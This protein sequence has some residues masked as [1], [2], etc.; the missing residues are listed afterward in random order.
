MKRKAFIG[1][2]GPIAYD[3]NNQSKNEFPS[4]HSS[5]NPILE[6]S[7]GLLLFY[8]ELIFLSPQL[9]PKNMRSLDFVKFLI[10]YEDFENKY[11]KALS[12]AEKIMVDKEKS[13]FQKSNPLYINTI[14]T[15]INS[16]SNKENFLTDHH[17]HK[18]NL[19]SN[20]VV[21][22]ASL[23]FNLVYVD[24][25]LIEE[26]NLKNCELI[27]NS[28][29]YF[30]IEDASFS[31]TYNLDKIKVANQLIINHLPNYLLKDGP[32]HECMLEL[33]HHKFVSNFRSHLDEI[34][35]FE[36]NNE[37]K[38]IAEELEM[39]A[40]QYRNN[41]FSR[42]LNDEIGYTTSSKAITLDFTGL[43]LPVAGSMS[44]FFD[45]TQEQA[46]KEKIKWAGFVTDIKNKI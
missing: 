9:C 28:G 39:T 41:I 13:N 44:N 12:K 40:K 18:F 6:D 22:A 29:N 15:I 5:P 45:Q 34:L 46:K 17:T 25:Q 7:M 20:I 16:S 2:S 23:Y 30:V 4:D 24:L 10:N 11:S 36:K 38:K 19:T 21:N 37:H 1:L 27:Y 31:D 43:V 14:Q 35:Y 8:D 42:Y 26:F 33:R 32:F 3:Y